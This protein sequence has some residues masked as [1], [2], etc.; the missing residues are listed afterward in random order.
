MF[1]V[2]ESK[3]NTREPCSVKNDQKT[4]HPAL[5]YTINTIWPNA[6]SLSWE[7]RSY[8]TRYRLS[9]TWTAYYNGPAIR[10]YT[11][12]GLQPDKD[13]VFYIVGYDNKNDSTLQKIIRLRTRGTS[14]PIGTTEVSNRVIDLHWDGGD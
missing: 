9:D 13:Y 11:I 7:R 12:T 8:L 6:V 10:E 1:N 2:M 3:M 4:I 14:F 5:D